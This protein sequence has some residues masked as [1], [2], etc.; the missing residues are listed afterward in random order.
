MQHEIVTQPKAM[1]LI[2]IGTEYR[3]PRSHSLLTICA[4]RD[5]DSNLRLVNKS[6]TPKPC[7][8]NVKVGSTRGGNI[9]I[10]AVPKRTILACL[11]H[12][13]LSCL[14]YICQF[15][16]MQD[17]RQHLLL[18]AQ[19]SKYHVQGNAANCL[20]LLKC[21]VDESS[22]KLPKVAIFTNKPYPNGVADSRQARIANI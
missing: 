22:T 12:C 4:W 5:V 14:A 19:G 3:Y 13:M 18:H 1:H 21:E 2:F 6:Q 11:Q 15:A 20:F 16:R 17:W 9:F 10:V 7:Y 8:G